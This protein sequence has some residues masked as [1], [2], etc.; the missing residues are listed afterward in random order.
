MISFSPETILPHGAGMRL[1][2]Q[3]GALLDGWMTYEVVMEPW[4]SVLEDGA[5][6]P[7]E[8][9]LEMMAQACGM[10]VAD[11]DNGAPPSA[12]IGVVGAVRGYTYTPL[13]FVVGERVSVRVKPEVLEA[14]VAVCEGEIYRAGNSS[15]DQRARITLVITK[16][17]DR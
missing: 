7:P 2:S 8:L 3:P 11:N 17:G 13:P 5:S 16:D 12:R 15:P 6:A 10:V 1:L 9:G 4:F 14:G